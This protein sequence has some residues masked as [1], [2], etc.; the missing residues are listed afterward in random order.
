V[1][2]R[3]H[4]C[5]CVHSTQGQTS[6]S[7]QHTD[8]KGGTLTGCGLNGQARDE[9]PSLPSSGYH[10]READHST[11][12]SVDIYSYE[13]IMIGMKAHKSCGI[14]GFLKEG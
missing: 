13:E 11:P 9:S 1:H 14:Y 4:A 2:V 6:L 8:S 5:V 7:S 10:G 12:P 3:A